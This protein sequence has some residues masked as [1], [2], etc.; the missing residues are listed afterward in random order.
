MMIIRAIKLMPTLAPKMAAAVALMHCPALSHGHTVTF[1]SVLEEREGEP[2]SD[3]VMGMENSP[4]SI[5]ITGCSIAWVSAYTEQKSRHG[6]FKIMKVV[7]DR[8]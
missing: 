5:S 6:N 7:K 8:K 3:T 2:E 1:T 4:W